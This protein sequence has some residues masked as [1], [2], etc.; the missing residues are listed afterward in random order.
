MEGIVHRIA[1]PMSYDR[2]QDGIS[3]F[4]MD[5]DD[6]H[7]TVDIQLT[8]IDSAFVLAGLID[9]FGLANV[10]HAIGLMAQ[11]DPTGQRVGL[12]KAGQTLKGE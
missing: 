10:M 9:H 1:G 12:T 4:A 6:N 3:F 11:E 5:M 8:A 7:K 2:C